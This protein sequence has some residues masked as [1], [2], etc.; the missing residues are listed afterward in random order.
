MKVAISTGIFLLIIVVAGCDPAEEEEERVEYDL[1]EIVESD[2]IKV[3][4]S[5][6]PTSYFLYRG[7]PMGY[8]YEMLSNLSDFLEVDLELRL[9]R[10]LADMFD[11]LETGEVDLIAHNLTITGSR[12]ENFAFTKPM[13][14]TQQVLV[15]AK[16]DG[17]RNMRLHEIDRELIRSPLDL[18]GETIHVRGGSAYESR[19]RNLA[20]EM[21]ADIDI[22]VAPDS[23][24]SEELIAMVADG[25][26]E[27]T[28]TDHNL[29]NINESYYP[30]LDIQ[31]EISFP[32]NL[33]WAVR[34]QSTELLENINGW[35]DD[36]Q[37]QT[38]YYVI[39]NKYFENR[40]AYRTRMNSDL[41]SIHS[42]RISIY[43]E[44]IQREVQ[45]IGWD[46]ELL[47]ALIHQESRFNPNAR[48]GAGA[49]G[50]MQL[51]PRTARAF[52]ADDPRD[53]EQSLRAGIKFITWLSNYWEEEIEDEDER[54]KFILASYNTGQGHVQDARRLAKAFGDADPDIWTD[55]VERYMLKKSDREYFNHEVVRHGYSRGSEPVNYVSRILYLHN[56]YDLVTDYH[57]DEPEAELAGFFKF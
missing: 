49:V 2:T 15:Q 43:D 27:Y 53:P 21:G 51:M 13:N 38:D 30:D 42:G 41:L 46:W 57:E 44:L 9:S 4:T 40:T 52:G 6:S 32:Q 56:H 37:S 50:L 18:D 35:L 17:W 1:E 20:Y 7:Q 19:L 31:T 16:P 14:T 10:S 23:I 22:A 29:A 34:N 28:V 39:Y 55:N 25:E 3:V 54:L 5:Y 33:A 11:M 8:N 48:S 47:A 24:T 45:T 36:F 12:T 26:I